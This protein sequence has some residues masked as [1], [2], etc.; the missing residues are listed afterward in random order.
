MTKFKAFVL[1]TFFMLA[2]IFLYPF[3][4]LLIILA[5]DYFRTILKKTKDA[6]LL[7]S[8]LYSIK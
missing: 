6:V 7:L 1:L 3:L 8:W 4:V 2:I 5:P